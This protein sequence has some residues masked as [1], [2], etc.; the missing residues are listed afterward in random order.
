VL[1][2]FLGDPFTNSHLVTLLTV[3]LL[4]NIAKRDNSFAELHN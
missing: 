4:K 2:Y 3:H 1:G